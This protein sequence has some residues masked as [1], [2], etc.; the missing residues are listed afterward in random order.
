MPAS[1]PNIL[2][3]L[4]DQ[5]S[6]TML[7][8]AGNPY[9][10][11]PAMDSLAAT[12]VRFERG[13]CGNPVC[14]PARFSFFTGLM[15]SALDI[16]NNDTSQSRPVTPELVRQTPGWRLGAAGYETAY[17]GKIHLPAGLSPQA[18]GF[19]YM[20]RDERDRLAETCADFI[21]RPRTRPF[22][23]VASFINPHDI[24]YMAIR[25]FPQDPESSRIIANGRT[26]LETLDRALARPAG[27][28]E[29]EF[30]ARHC[31]PLPDNHLPQ[32]GEPEAIER[33]LR[34]RP[35]KWGVRESWSEERWRLHRWA[36]C[37]LTEAVDAQIGTVLA[38]LRE[39]GQEEETV[40]IFTSDH[41]D[42]DGAHKME[43]KDVLYEESV[44][45]PFIISQPGRTSAAVDRSHL[46]SNGLDLLPTLCDYAGAECP[47]DRAGV[48][49]RPLAEGRAP[50]KWREWL[51]VECEIGDLIVTERYKYML[52]HHGARAEQLMDLAR[53]PGETRNA[54]ND[55]EHAAA[56]ARCRANF[57]AAFPGVAAGCGQ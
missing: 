56:L 48:S 49:L 28:S 43:H 19:E 57:A 53:D 16:R 34:Q 42:N 29:A 7:S 35:F 26:E 36:Y 40:V 32:T 22:F 54:L 18:M 46:V 1:R 8:C 55:P 24:C 39:S 38:A 10:R 33:L 31:P 41:G 9:L 6:A 11:T 4:T 23:L 44:R 37:R 20:L 13:Y 21:R 51:P 45:I 47:A 27:V 52:H 25:D 12:G 3:V 50:A 15:P 17:G 5:Q 30:F 14:L 2:L